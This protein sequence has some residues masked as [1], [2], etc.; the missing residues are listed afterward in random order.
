M[1]SRSLVVDAGE[2]RVEQV[3]SALSALGGTVFLE[4]A[5][6]RAGLVAVG[7]PPGERDCGLGFGVCDG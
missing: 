7:E 2:Q 6:E 4:R 3:H 1:I 5:T